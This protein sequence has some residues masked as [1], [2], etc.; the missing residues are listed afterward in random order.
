MYDDNDSSGASLPP[1][2]SGG[3]GSSWRHKLFS[4]A[5]TIIP[6]V[7][8]VL[9]VLFFAV[10]FM[11]MNV[12]SIPVV[13]D[14][15]DNFGGKPRMLIVGSPDTDTKGMFAS[16]S[17]MN[18]YTFDY[19]NAEALGRRPDEVISK[20]DILIFDQTQDI[21]KKV[22]KALAEAAIDYVKSGGSVI[23]V[24]DSAIGITGREDILGLSGV[25]G[26]DVSP[27]DCSNNLSIVSPCE[28]IQY[29]SGYMLNPSPGYNRVLDSI[30]QVPPRMTDPPLQWSTY[31]I[32]E[33]G[34][35]IGWMYFLD[36]YNNNYP[37]I[38]YRK[39]GVLGGK[40]VYFNYHEIWQTKE[41][42]DRVLEDLS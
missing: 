11:D 25:F 36:T 12:S 9:F 31:P 6:I 18:K 2:S 30:D 7:L 10:S 38:V 34:D 17:F 4:K 37:A 24:G 35:S 27:I 41:I 22:P 14:W 39:A 20:F 1:L 26:S 16:E 28:D 3:S 33:I 42:V 19:R 15:L 8:I 21:S 29:I 13:G 23:V 5:E 40:F 32:N